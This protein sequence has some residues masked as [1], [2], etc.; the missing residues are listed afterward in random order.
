MESPGPGQHCWRHAERD[1]IR[2]GIQFAS[3]VTAGSRQA[4]HVA[5]QAIEQNREA[6]GNRRIV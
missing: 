4:C 3:K 2:K 1:Y 5:V 6:D